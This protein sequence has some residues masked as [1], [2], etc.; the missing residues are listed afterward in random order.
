MFGHLLV[1]ITISFLPFSCSVLTLHK[2]LS[3]A[4]QIVFYIVTDLKKHGSAHTQNYNISC[5]CLQEVLNR[6]SCACHI[7]TSYF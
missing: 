5:V 6:S 4:L 7:R 2:D 3:K 1:Q